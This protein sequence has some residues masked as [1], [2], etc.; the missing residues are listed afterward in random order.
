WDGADILS[1]KRTSFLVLDEADRMLDMGFEKDIL[2]IVESL[3]KTRQTLFFTATWPRVVQRIADMILNKP[4][5]INIGKQGE[6]VA[7]RDVQQVVEIVDQR[8]KYEKLKAILKD[9]APTD[10]VIVFCNRKTECYDL[11]NALWNEKLGVGAIHG[12][13]TQDEREWT[14]GCF[15]SG[16]S[17]ILIATDVAARGL[18]IK[19]VDRVINYDFPTQVEDYVHRIGRTGRAGAKGIANTFFTQ[20]DSRCSRDLVKIMKEA[21]QTVSPDLEEMGRNCRGGGKGWGKGGKGKGGKGG[22]GKGKG[23]K[24]GGWGG[25]WS[26]GGRG[27][28]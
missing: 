23:G 20:A 7:N 3:P 15:K 25:G 14:L 8:E 4:I 13:K 21:N 6:L 22:K 1:M 2:K 17:P 9:C 26:G 5:R 12:D 16:E 11:E 10:K 19:G 18:D 28:W 27:R 24:G